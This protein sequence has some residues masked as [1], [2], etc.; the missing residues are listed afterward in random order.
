VPLP[1]IEQKSQLIREMDLQTID[2]KIDVAMPL[3]FSKT[4]FLASGK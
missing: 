3:D 4:S 2:L 1:N